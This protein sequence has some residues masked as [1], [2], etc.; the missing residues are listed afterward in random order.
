MVRRKTM[1]ISLEEVEQVARLARLKVSGA[2]KEHFTHQLNQIL[3]YMDKLNE[4]DTTGV[5][6]TSHAIDLQ[7]VFR[8]DLVQQSLSRDE[9][10]ENAPE[11]N[12]ADFIVPRVI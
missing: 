9:S 6:P 1:K 3:L 2:E 10:L 8:E 12:R 7:N 5:A 4:L 11:S